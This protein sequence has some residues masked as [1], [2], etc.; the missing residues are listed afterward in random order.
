[1]NTC[2]LLII[3][4]EYKIVYE[5]QNMRL[6]KI[7][8]IEYYI[9]YFRVCSIAFLSLLM[10]FSILLMSKIKQAMRL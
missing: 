9:L 2:K 8:K 7:L 4:N 1:M 6:D 3:E 10:E 5:L